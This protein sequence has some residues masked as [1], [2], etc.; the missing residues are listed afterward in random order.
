MIK[1]S[2]DKKI[3]ILLAVIGITIIS[4]CGFWL[5]FKT[6]FNTYYNANKIFIQAET[7]VLKNKTELF[8][9]EEKPITQAQKKQFDD[10]IKKTSSILQY[11]TESSYFEDAL[12]MTGK[13]FYYQQN[14]SRALR[15][16]NELAALSGSS[17][18]LESKLWIGKTQLQL[19]DFNAAIKIL[20]EVI[21]EAV[22]NDET[23]I[24]IEAYKSKIGYLIYSEDFE[25][26]I[27]ESNNFFNED[28]LEELKAEILYELGL[29]YLNNN[30][31]VE[32][33]NS[34]E[35]V[36]N[37]SPNFEIDFNSK[38]ELAKLSQ[39]TGELDKS[40]ELFEGLRAEDKFS[41]NWNLL[42]LQM[43]KIYYDQKEIE[44]AL[45]KFTYVDTT[46]AKTVSSGT[47]QFY[48]AEILE[49]YYFDYDSALV[50]YQKVLSSNADQETKNNAQKKSTLLNKYINLH[51]VNKELNLKYLYLTDD[52]AF[53][54]DS[55]DY[56]FKLKEDSIKAKIEAEAAL[57]SEGPTQ[58]GRPK[59][60]QKVIPK[61]PK[62]E[63]PKISVDSLHSLFSQNYFELANLLYT[64]FD[65]PDSAFFYYQK[66]LEEKENNPNQ[67]Q[68]YYAIGSYYLL[69]N[70]KNKADSIFSIVYEKFPDNPIRNEAAKQIGKPIYDF[71]K[72]PL[73]EDFNY[74]ESLY[75][76]N[77]YDSA[78]E[79][80]FKIYR[81]NRTSEYA[82][83]SLY[84]IGYILE[85]EL[86]LPDSAASIYDTLTSKY[87]NSVY[88]KD[89][90][91]RLTGFK[92][93]QNRLIAIQDSIKKAEESLIKE[94][95]KI[96]KTEVN[97][98]S[99]SNIKVDSLQIP[100]SK[101]KI[102]S[103][104]IKRK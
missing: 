17:L 73:E 5:D 78:I 39:K 100:D 56:I 70:D 27:E 103:T 12:L 52:N 44:K 29:L 66:S 35:K 46:Y 9:Y 51:K 69:N 30:E 99:I 95:L 87:R 13:S 77:K 102:D 61:I 45:E 83:K 24:L 98:N 23:Q 41:D 57:E 14:Y 104:E 89:V 26:A 65:N 59:Q 101:V 7:E 49:N 72:D 25:S 6:Y 81:S 19:R 68:T 11:S 74:A 8:Y 38:F 88:A 1:F 47:A 76:D 48:R 22:D 40:L 79:S 42:D 3:K 64:E 33:K 37:Y 16:F 50:F 92:Q 54:K 96:D 10:V 91:L 31:L 53:R 4:G 62:P 2:F 15:K 93:E 58:K 18:F 20:N 80:L 55:L 82:P 97:A 21:E 36:Q 28:I 32:A 71:K 75:E 86:N 43:A 90:L 34:F 84:T 94:K 67:A 63:R 60:Q 85:K